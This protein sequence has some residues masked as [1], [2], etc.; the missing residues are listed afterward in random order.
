MGNVRSLGFIA[1]NE[2]VETTIHRVDKITLV[3]IAVVHQVTDID[4]SL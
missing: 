1:A 4:E 3:P 2:F